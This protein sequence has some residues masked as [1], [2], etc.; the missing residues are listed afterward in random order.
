[1]YGTVVRVLTHVYVPASL[2]HG[3]SVVEGAN[4]VQDAIELNE[5][6]SLVNANSYALYA[7]GESGLLFFFFFFSL[8]FSLF[9]SSFRYYTHVYYST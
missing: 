4:F 7:S 8:F 5:T 6:E 9:F 1:M 3:N 2:D